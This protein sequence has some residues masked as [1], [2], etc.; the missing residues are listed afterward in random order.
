M[1]Y[2]KKE[3]RF[4]VTECEAP[5]PE[6]LL[7]ISHMPRFI[8]GTDD[9]DAKSRGWQSHGGGSVSR[10]A[11]QGDVASLVPK[12]LQPREPRVV[13]CCPLFS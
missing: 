3:K 6:A 9:R 4:L 5:S 7:T 8:P 11:R 2:K 10:E 12:C 13:S 1:N